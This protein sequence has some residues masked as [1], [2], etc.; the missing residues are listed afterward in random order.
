[1]NEMC[2]LRSTAPGS[3]S[4]PKA[5]TAT[6]GKYT[7]SRLCQFRGA[8]AY[9]LHIPCHG[10]FVVLRKSHGVCCFNA[11]HASWSIPWPVP[12]LQDPLNACQSDQ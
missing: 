11:W 8:N 1:M 6:H 5:Q 4:T 9:S 10:I 7:S 12:V 2:I 3:Q